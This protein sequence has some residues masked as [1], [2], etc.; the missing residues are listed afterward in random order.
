MDTTA[1]AGEHR[2]WAAGRTGAGPAVPGKYLSLTSYRRDGTPVATPVW[3][4]QDGGRILVQTDAGSG[5]AR[6]IRRNPAVTI[7]PC[8]GTGRLRGHPIPA[9][10]RQLPA[11]ENSRAE[12]L[13]RRKYR[14]DIAVLRVARAAQSVF[15]RGASLTTSV[16]IEIVPG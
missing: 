16:I 1:A 7:A 2:P 15:R 6:R 4:V 3:F 5:K 10:A 12:A 14:V 11:T 13:L 8:T 9:S